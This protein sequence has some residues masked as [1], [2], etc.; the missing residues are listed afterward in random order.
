MGKRFEATRSFLEEYLV[1]YYN[2]ESIGLESQNTTSF[3]IIFFAAFIILPLY[4]FGLTWQILLVVLGLLAFFAANSIYNKKNGLKVILKGDFIYFYKGNKEPVMYNLKDVDVRHSFKSWTFGRGEH[5]FS[6]HLC[7]TKGNV[8]EYEAIIRKRI[9]AGGNLEKNNYVLG[10]EHIIAFILFVNMLKMDRLDKIENL[11]YRD[12][13]MG[14]IRR[15]SV[16]TQAAVKRMIIM[17]IGIL[18]VSMF[19]MWGGAYDFIGCPPK[20]L[21]L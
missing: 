18:L 3:L 9:G 10:C 19:V 15:I 1:K 5:V 8:V 13:Y 7:I 14:V 4:R 11:D 2:K 21:L 6:Y 12:D 17:I 20:L 16:T